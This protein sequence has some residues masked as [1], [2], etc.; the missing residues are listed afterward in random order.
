MKAKT[1]QERVTLLLSKRN[2]RFKFRE[3]MSLAKVSRKELESV[4]VEIRKIR[5]DL[6][7][8]KFDKTFYFAL[9]PTWYSN[10]TDLSK[11]MPS[12]GKFGLISDTH[13][14]S[15]AQRLDILKIAYREFKRQG[16]RQVFHTGD[17]TDGWQEYRGHINFVNIY[18]DQPQAL[19]VI[20]HYPYKKGITTYV[21]G[22]NHDDSYKHTQI[23]RLS[24]VTHGF[25][26]KGRDYEGRKDIIYLGQY[27][28]RIIL[29]QQITMDLLHPRGGNP[30]ARSYKAQR[31]SENMDRN[32]R[33]DIQCSGHFHAHNFIWLNHTYFLDSPGMQDET[34]FFKR[35]GFP[36][37]VGFQIVE[38]RI[39]KAE[40]VSLKPELFMFS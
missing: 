39:R 37:N 10:Q 9:T 15:V 29:P 33:P 35:L 16:V 18:G 32:L 24:L 20:Q 27:S 31:R 14:C 6:I 5:K 40:L 13:L 7:Y 12:H 21:I 30:Y 22:G 23:D 3:L 1:P 25:H 34:E 2:A 36:R 19:Y 11:V 28:H 4:I 38:Y 26:N 8:A 17:M